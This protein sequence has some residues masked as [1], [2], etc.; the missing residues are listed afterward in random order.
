[1]PKGQCNLKYHVQKITGGRGGISSEIEKASSCINHDI[2]VLLSKMQFYGISGKQ[3][4]YKNII[5]TI[6]IKEYQ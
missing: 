5:L 3:K 6:D 4:H 1:M 2:R